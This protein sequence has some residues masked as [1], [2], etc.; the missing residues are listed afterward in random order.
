MIATVRP[1]LRDISRTSSARF[2]WS[3]EVPWEKL[4]RTTS[5]PARTIALSSA[6]GT[7]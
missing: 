2:S 3:S 6:A 5:T 7:P 4:R 1:A